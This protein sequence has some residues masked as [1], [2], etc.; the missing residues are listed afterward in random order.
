MYHLCD[1]QTE[2]RNVFFR[3][4]L[5]FPWKSSLD[6]SLYKR[7]HG[8][9]H[10]AGWRSDTGIR[11]AHGDQLP[12][13]VQHGRRAL[14]RTELPRQWRPREQVVRY[15]EERRALSDDRHVS[16]FGV[17]IDP[18]DEHRGL[19]RTMIPGIRYFWDSDQAISRQFAAIATD[20][21]SR[22]VYRPFTL[23]LDP[24][25]R[26]IANIALIPAQQHHRARRGP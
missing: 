3:T 16:F 1:R 17:S 2:A 11:R 13:R 26:V 5:G 6:L 14:Y 18:N 7:L 25:Q 24:M 22:A 10:V 12:I 4:H 8:P 9:N 21:A 23:V 15:I 19:L 20:Q